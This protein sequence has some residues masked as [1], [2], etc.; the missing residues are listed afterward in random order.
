[1]ASTACAAGSVS[2]GIYQT[3]D[4]MDTCSLWVMFFLGEF[5][6]LQRISVTTWTQIL[7]SLGAEGHIQSYVLTEVLEGW[8]CSK[9]KRVMIVSSL[10]VMNHILKFLEILTLSIQILTVASNFCPCGLNKDK[11]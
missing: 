8:A 2:S 11:T 5:I 6:R 3:R 4:A 10:K 9:V 1:M 7:N